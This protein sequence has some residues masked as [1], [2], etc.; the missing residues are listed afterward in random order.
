[1]VDDQGRFQLNYIWGNNVIIVCA[2]SKVL[3]A[4]ALNVGANE[5]INQLH[6]NLKSGKVEALLR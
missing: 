1:M 2:G 3:L 5:A 4:S 6:I